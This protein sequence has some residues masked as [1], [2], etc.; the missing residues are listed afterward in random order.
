M[1]EHFKRGDQLKPGVGMENAR[2]ATDRLCR[3]GIQKVISAGF[4]GALVPELQIG[5]IVEDRIATVRYPVRNSEERKALAS[6]A[7]L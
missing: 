3:L 6:K 5:D 4:C 2:K 1:L 7:K